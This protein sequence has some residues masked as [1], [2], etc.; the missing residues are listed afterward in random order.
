MDSLFF[1][2]DR[3]PI[4]L[5]SMVRKALK[6]RRVVVALALGVPV[7]LFVLF[8]SRGI[9]QRLRLLHEKSVMQE[10]VIA[11]ETKQRQLR[12]ELKAL[13]GDRAAIERVAREKHGMV[14]EGETLYKVRREKKER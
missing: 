11:A 3:K 2:K 9:V 12:A 1:R 10:N 5:R 13:D 7:M 4:D 14:R 8:G 6:N